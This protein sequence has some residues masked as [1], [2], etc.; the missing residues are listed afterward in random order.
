[1][2]PVTRSDFVPALRAAHC[3]PA[4]AMR[5]EGGPSVRPPSYRST[6]AI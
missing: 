1:M 2:A 6:C 3:D 4:I 5:A